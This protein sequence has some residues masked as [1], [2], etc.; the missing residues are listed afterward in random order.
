M[1]WSIFFGGPQP[2]IPE[3]RHYRLASPAWTA[4]VRG[5]MKLYLLAAASLVLSGGPRWQASVETAI[6]TVH[7]AI[8]YG[9]WQCRQVWLTDCQSKCAAQGRT[10]MG[11]MWLADIKTQVDVT[12]FW[13]HSYGHGKYAIV[14]CCCD[15][16]EVSPTAPI[17]KKQWDPVREEVR[18]QWE[19]QYGPWPTSGS[20]PWDAHHIQD[21]GHGGA[22]ADPRNV[23]P[24]PKDVHQEYTRQYDV[25]YGGEG[26]WS[27]PGPD[28]PYVD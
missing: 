23:I 21:L 11:C 18:S 9:P 4:T 19:G 24:V 10:S 14:H 12:L 16:P 2:G 13:S 27:R 28:H 26:Q 5:P 1:L 6:G 25:C 7:T 8:Y 17:R 20:T 22:P 3:N 15:W